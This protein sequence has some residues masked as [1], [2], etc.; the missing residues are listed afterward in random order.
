M[1]QGVGFSSITSAAPEA[2]FGPA[3]F[4]A[5]KNQ[6]T[7]SRAE[8]FNRAVRNDRSGLLGAGASLALMSVG[9][10]EAYEGYKLAAEVAV[11]AV[12]LILSIHEATHPS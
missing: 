6:A 7:P 8:F 1:D 12:H 11:E 10:S 2:A 9:V 5:F 4:N 3:M